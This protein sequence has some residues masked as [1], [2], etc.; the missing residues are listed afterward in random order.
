MFGFEDEPI[1]E[2]FASLG[3]KSKYFIANFGA[4]TIVFIVLLVAVLLVKILSYSKMKN[5]LLGFKVIKTFSRFRRVNF[6]LLLPV[7]NLTYTCLATSTLLNLNELNYS[8]LPHLLNTAAVI[9]SMTSLLGI[10]IALA[11]IMYKK[12]QD[13]ESI[14]YL[15]HFTDKLNTNLL[16][17]RV[18]AVFSILF[19][20]RR[21]IQIFIIV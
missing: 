17:K 16:D 9:I 21:F 19:F 4:L 15:K 11:Y 7:F 1:S 5:K 2:H 8:T 14:H 10:P 12:W 6:S 3:F 18:G 20:Y 13:L